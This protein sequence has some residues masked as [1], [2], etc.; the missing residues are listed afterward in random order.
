[1][2]WTIT[3]RWRPSDRKGSDGAL[4]STRLSLAPSLPCRAVK[5]TTRTLWPWVALRSTPGRST[6]RHPST[7]SAVPAHPG[8]ATTFTTSLRLTLKSRGAWQVVLPRH[9][10]LTLTKSARRQAQTSRLEPSRRCR[11]ASRSTS[12]GWPRGERKCRAVPRVRRLPLTT[13]A[14]PVRLAWPRT[15]TTCRSLTSSG[16]TASVAA[17]AAARL[18][19]LLL[20]LHRRRQ[21]QT[22]RL[23]PNRRCR[24]AS[25]STSS[26]WPRGSANA[27]RS[28]ESAASH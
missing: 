21:A 12:S 9:H 27:E 15:S 26:G 10:L 2:A 13:S 6:S 22:S 20:R 28:R 25:R 14:V 19:R 18:H 7:L 11:D 24:D 1:M 23:E 17:V 4:K 3:T 5:R 8:C 16:H